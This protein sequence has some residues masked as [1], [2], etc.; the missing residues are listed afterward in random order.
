M[1]VYTE[2][3][4]TDLIDP[5]LDIQNYRSEHRLVK[6]NFYASNLRLVNVGLLHTGAGPLGN[7]NEL[8]GVFGIIKKIEL[9]DGSKVLDSVQNFN[10][11]QAFR[12]YNKRNEVNKD[13]LKHLTQNNMGFVLESQLTTTSAAKVEE[14]KI[15]PYENP[16]AIDQD[17]Q[18]T[19]RGWLSLVDVFPL[20]KAMPFIHCGLFQNFRIV[21]EYDGIRSVSTSGNHSV[22]ETTQPLLLADNILNEQLAQQFLSNFKGVQFVSY[23]NERVVVPAGDPADDDQ[24]IV[25]K[26]QGFNKKSV[27]RVLISKNAPVYDATKQSPLFNIL[28][29][30]A[31]LEETLNIRVNGTNKF[32]RDGIIG[33][34]EALGLLHDTFGTC[35]TVVGGNLPSLVNGANHY[36]DESHYVGHLDYFGFHLGGEYI[37]DLQL[38]YYREIDGA[39]DKTYQQLNLNVFG[40]VRKQLVVNG[41][42]YDIMYI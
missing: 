10:T 30:E 31:Q 34:N 2:N 18:I 8:C 27:D 12:S 1:S 41:G 13:T 22:V 4:R 26:L 15:R 35:N 29:S 33:K 24:S 11:L 21:V 37:S 19:A 39:N 3:V 40:E 25:Q 32:P 20:L 17:G 9:L 7:A 42:V 23:E 16:R 36:A 38:D 5:I 14:P 28:G 6:N